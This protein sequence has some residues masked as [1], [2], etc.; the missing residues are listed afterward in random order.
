M[1]RLVAYKV[2]S[3]LVTDCRFATSPTNRV[4]SGC[5]RVDA[6]NAQ[7]RGGGERKLV[8]GQIPRLLE[9]KVYTSHGTIG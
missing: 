8:K 1:R 3:G 2:D 5:R 7:T 6:T 4:P 9:G